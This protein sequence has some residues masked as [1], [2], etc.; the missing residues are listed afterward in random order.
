M[1][2]RKRTLNVQRHKVDAAANDFKENHLHKFRKQKGF[3]GVTV[4][5]NRNT[6]EMTAI[7]FWETEEDVHG[8]EDLGREASESVSRAGDAEGDSGA[9]VL[10]VLVDD[11]A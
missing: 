11:T 2:A 3:K 7:S 4:L 8:S 10:E 5:A 6:G 9:E 1:H